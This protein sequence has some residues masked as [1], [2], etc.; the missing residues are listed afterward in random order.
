MEQLHIDTEQQL[1]TQDALVAQQPEQYQFMSELQQYQATVQHT[2][3]CSATDR[4][5]CVLRTT[6]STNGHECAARCEFAV[7]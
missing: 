4:S 1:F 5:V 6:S 7:S 3:Y 2:G